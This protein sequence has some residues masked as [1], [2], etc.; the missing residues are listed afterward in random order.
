MNTI[1]LST[2]TG[3]GGHIVICHWQ[4]SYCHLSLAKEVIM[5]SI[6]HAMPSVPDWDMCFRGLNQLQSSRR[7]Y[8]GNLCPI[9]YYWRS[10]SGLI[11][12][13]YN[14]HSSVVSNVLIWH[15]IKFVRAASGLPS[16]ILLSSI[17]ER[18]IW[19]FIIG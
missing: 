10:Q 16:A 5:S 17:T 1:I 8:L 19:S 3:K 4:R 15:C 7:S 6:T 13:T 18:I 2:I 12:W 14:T 9:R 11:P